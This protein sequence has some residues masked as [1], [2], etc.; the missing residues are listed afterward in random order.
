ML[1]LWEA[2]IAS[3]WERCIGWLV[4]WRKLVWRSALRLLL[5]LLLL[6]GALLSRHC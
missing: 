2:S 4:A 5:L 1:L 3:R 6:L